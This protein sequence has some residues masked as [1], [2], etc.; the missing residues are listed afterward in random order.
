MVPRSRGPR[1]AHRRGAVVAL[2]LILLLLVVAGCSGERPRFADGPDATLDRSTTTVAPRPG[3]VVVD[4]WSEAFCGAFRSW[5]DDAAAAGDSLTEELEDT[6]DPATVRDSL[7]AM[8]DDVATR[9]D[10]F[11]DEVRDGDVPD[12]EGG[13]ALVEALA[14]RFDELAE[15]FRGYR[16]RAA[17]I[18]IAD[19]DRFQ[20]DVDEVLASMSVGQERVARSFEEIDRDFPDAVLQRAL[21]R[22][23]GTS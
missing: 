4:T 19:P 1:R 8:L 10:T 17:D 5:Q 3:T 7:V 21:R 18:D 16:E 23:C 13:E 11:A 12:V 22:S 15:T 20:A 14:H 9:T 6:A 2:G